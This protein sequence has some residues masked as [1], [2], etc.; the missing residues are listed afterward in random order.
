M[1]I[2]TKAGPEVAV[3]MDTWDGYEGSRNRILGG[4]HERGVD[5]VLFLTGDLHRSLAADLKLDFLD[6]ASPTVGVELVGTSITSGRDGEDNDAGGRTIL[7]ENPWI[8]YGNFQRGYVRCTVTPDEF[9]ADYR[10]ADRVTT[11]GGAMSTRTTLVVE[12]GVP[13]LQQG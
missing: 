10:V 13:G 1:R 3:P 11:P 6:P 7:A 5:N 4:I 9:R 12:N 8:R 2:D